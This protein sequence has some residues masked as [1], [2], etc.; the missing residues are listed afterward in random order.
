[1][2][3]RTIAQTLAGLPDEMRGRPGYSAQARREHAARTIER[4]YGNVLEALAK[5]AFDP[6]GDQ[7]VRLKA[8]GTLAPYL[9]PAMKA[10]ELS[11]PDGERLVVEVR[12]ATEG[13]TGQPER[14][15]PAA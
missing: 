15:A 13:A 3:K 9:F 12:R 2:A 4:K 10:V 5:L 1:M 11:G 8:L 6:N 7:G 14:Q